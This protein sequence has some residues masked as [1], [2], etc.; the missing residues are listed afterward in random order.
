MLQFNSKGHLVP[1]TIIESTVKE[2]KEEFVTNIPSEKRKEIFDKYI[3]YSDALKAACNNRSFI[4]WINGSFTTKK[5]DPG[6]I[7]IVSFIDH[8]FIQSSE[9]LF[10]EFAYPNS[11]RNFN[12]DAYIVSV[13]P[14]NHK[15]HFLFT[16]D[17]IDWQDRFN[18]SWMNR[19]GKRFPKGFLEIMF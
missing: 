12:V 19:A 7:D 17:M 15:L 1:P 9:S 6:D 10:A 5:Y 3:T 11:E 16:S 13:Y 18:K 4:Q 8:T 14:E 2:L